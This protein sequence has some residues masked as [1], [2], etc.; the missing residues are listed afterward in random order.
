MLH[1]HPTGVLRGKKMELKCKTTIQDV[2]D[3]TII[4]RRLSGI[5][6]KNINQ[7]R[8]IYLIFLLIS[9]CL[10]FMAT[11]AKVYTTLIM[12]AI[13]IVISFINI[14]FA[15]KI[16]NKNFKKNVLKNYETISKNY[17][18]DF[19]EPTDLNIKIENGFVETESLGSITKYP[20]EDFIRNF[21]EDRFS[22]F[23][24]KNGKFLFINL[25]EIT[26]DQLEEFCKELINK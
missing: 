7:R 14:I 16:N 18:H 23:E 12:S 5:E 9:I 6:E 17:N 3:A 1:G 15:K 4:V 13:L 21:K 2:I 24:F 25:K 20:I 10:L 22:I 11:K 26:E 19:L 8:I